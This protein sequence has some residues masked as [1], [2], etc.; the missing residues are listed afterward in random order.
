MAREVWKPVVGYEDLYQVS[1]RGRVKSLRHRLEFILR[2]NPSPRG[3]PVVCLIKEG[4]PPLYVPLGIL[5]LSHFESPRNG[6]DTAAYRNEDKTDNRVENLY[7][8]TR[9]EAAKEGARKR[10]ENRNKHG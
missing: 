8:K 10:I 7:W 2:C 9:K 5:V 6:D 4:A 3:H 1:N